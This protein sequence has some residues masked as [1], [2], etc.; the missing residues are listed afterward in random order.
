MLIEI[1]NWKRENYNCNNREKNI[2]SE[3]NTR[4]K[5]KKE[6]IE[7]NNEIEELTNAMEKMK[8]IKSVT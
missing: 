5:Q 1:R 7:L 3:I 2:D 8:S 6:L 4:T